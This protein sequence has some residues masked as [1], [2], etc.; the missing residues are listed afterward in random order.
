VVAGKNKRQ[1]SSPHELLLR[2]L[3]HHWSS[4]RAL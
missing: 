1:A 4:G 3:L 2:I